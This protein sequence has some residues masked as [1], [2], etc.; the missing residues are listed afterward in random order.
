MLVLVIEKRTL[1]N[2]KR[3]H[4]SIPV[5]LPADFLVKFKSLTSI[6]LTNTLANAT[7]KLRLRLLNLPLRLKKK[8]LLKLRRKPTGGIK[9]GSR[10]RL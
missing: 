3:R 4:V 5:R 10:K 2:L 1:K 7:R 8:S 6:D 9:N